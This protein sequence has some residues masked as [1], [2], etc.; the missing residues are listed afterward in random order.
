MYTCQI[1]QNSQ[2]ENE[3]VSNETEIFDSNLCDTS[4]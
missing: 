3:S 2:E 4:I 1:V